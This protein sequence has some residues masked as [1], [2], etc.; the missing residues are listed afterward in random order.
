MV[1]ILAATLFYLSEA[2]AR[3]YNYT[4]F[5]VPEATRNT[6]PFGINNGGT[7]AGFYYQNGFYHGFIKT[8]GGSYTTIDVDGA[9]DTFI[10]GIN[11]NGRIVGGYGN[12]EVYTSGHG[13]IYD[14][15][16]YILPFPF[17]VPG[18]FGSY[19]AGINL[20]GQIAGQYSQDGTFQG[21]R[22]FLWSGGNFTTLS[23][24]VAISYEPRGI[25]DAGW[26][27]GSYGDV[28][29]IN[30]G[31]IRSPGGAFSTFDVPGATHTL[32]SG[33]NNHNW[34]SGWYRHNDGTYHGFVYDGLAFSYIDVA[35]AD[36]TQV[37]GINDLGQVVG[38][39][40]DHGFLATPVRDISGLL[41]LLLGD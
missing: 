37:W 24:P 20:T 26:I 39:Y 25:N 16:T 22:G 11:A 12:P 35:G 7:I 5:D 30:H 2:Q 6:V 29:S 28:N 34:I 17:D 10:Y 23:E 27:V 8:A 15:G 18:S 32:I 38:T 19:P 13:F 21:V 31:F 36:N 9:S 1:A 33:I 4:S 41:L 3:T 14:N 40:A